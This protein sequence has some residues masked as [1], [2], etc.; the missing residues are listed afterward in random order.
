MEN[1]VRDAAALTLVGSQ[2]EVLRM[3]F[4]NDPCL[5]VVV[6][7]LPE[8]SAPASSDIVMLGIE[9]FLLLDWRHVTCSI[10]VLSRGCIAT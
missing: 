5:G 1:F 3:V 2:V 6:T 10:L 9:Q 4:H 7:A 8:V